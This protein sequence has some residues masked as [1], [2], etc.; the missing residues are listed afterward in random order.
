[1]TLLVF[2]TDIPV[3]K[4]LK[5][6]RHMC[7]APWWLQNTITSLKTNCCFAFPSWVSDCYSENLGSV[8]SD[9]FVYTESHCVD[10]A[11]RNK[12]VF[13]PSPKC[14]G[15]KCVLPC[16]ALHGLLGTVRDLLALLWLIWLD[17][18]LVLSL[19]HHSGSLQAK[20]LI[21]SA[22]QAPLMRMLGSPAGG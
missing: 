20:P 1:M 9:T 14:W 10:K 22:Q 13:G 12:W 5:C 8:L 15:D 19:F 17:K 3:S 11:F 18:Q 21:E 7:Q 16:P 6:S 2:P 4:H